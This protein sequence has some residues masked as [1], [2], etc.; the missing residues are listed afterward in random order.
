MIAL[1]IGTSRL[2]RAANTSGPSASTGKPVFLNFSLISGSAKILTSSLASRSTIGFGVHAGAK[3]PW[4]VSDS[5]SLMPSS[6]S[7]GTFGRSGQRVFDVTA[8]GRTFPALSSPVSE[9]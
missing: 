1:Y 3:M 5:A 6:S 2:M 7:V 8:T 4:K 9:P